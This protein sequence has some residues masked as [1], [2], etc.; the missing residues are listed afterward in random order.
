MSKY[1]NY[2]LLNGS[3]DTVV[4]IDLD[5]T[6]TDA[7][8]NNTYDFLIYCYKR[9]FGKP[10]LLLYKLISFIS[11]TLLLLT[12]NKKYID[13]NYLIVTLHMKMLNALGA[14]VQT[15]SR[16]SS[17]WILN[18]LKQG[19]LRIDVLSLIKDLNDIQ[20]LFTACIDI[21]ACNYARLLKLRDCYARHTY[22]R[23]NLFTANLL[24]L[25]FLCYIL[26]NYK[27]RRIIYV[28]D[29]KSYEVEKNV[30]KYMNA[31]VVV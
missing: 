25:Q 20:I 19:K 9:K 23:I 21:V 26:K 16:Y 6:I 8:I 10:G 30:L 5:G 29:K 31:N 14:D 15:L 18:I 22:P 27:P 12:Y 17:E 7:K 11:K 24:K 13:K 1:S 28:L 2:I 4:L 3:Y